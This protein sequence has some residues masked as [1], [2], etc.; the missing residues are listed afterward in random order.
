MLDYKK[1]PKQYHSLVRGIELLNQTRYNSLIVKSRNGLGKSWYVDYAIDKLGLDAVVLKGTMTEAK[2][3]EFV[4]A[5]RDKWIVLRDCGHLWRKVSFID[6]LKSATD[7]IPERI[8]TRGTYANH[9]GVEQT[10]KFTGKII[11]ELNTI[12]NSFKEDLNAVISRSLFVELNFSNTDVK[13]IIYQIFDMNKYKELIK[14]VFNSS[15]IT[16]ILNIRTIDKCIQIYEASIANKLDYKSQIIPYISNPFMGIKKDL[17]KIAGNKE[18]RRM[19]FV[20]YLMREG[21]S[22]G[23]AQRRITEGL[24]LG[25]IQSNGLQ[26]QAYLRV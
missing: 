8:I 3:F 4:S 23:T 5:N 22:Y 26:K 14:F 7:P 21:I 10:I 16:N 15:D 6:F 9:P 20:R 1:I 25:D 11:A 17:Y 18:I 12:P 24:F 2:F 13:Q 19:N